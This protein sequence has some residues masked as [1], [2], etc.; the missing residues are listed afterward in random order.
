MT[1]KVPY[2]LVALDLDGTLLT[3]DHT[4]SAETMTALDRVRQLG[5]KIVI[6]TGKTRRSADV[7]WQQLGFQGAGVYSQGL[8]VYDETDKVI[9]RRKLP[10]KVV[11]ELEEW[12]RETQ[13]T[14]IAY[15][16]NRLLSHQPSEYSERLQN[17]HEPTVEMVES[18]AKH[19]INKIIICAPVP[20]LEANLPTLSQRWPRHVSLIRA[21]IADFVEM[22]PITSSKGDGLRRLLARLG[23]TWL[24]VLAMGNAENDIE[25]LL[26]AGCGVA[27]DNAPDI[28]KAAANF[29]APSNDDDGVAVALGHLFA[30]SPA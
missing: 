10:T 29:V 14:L 5:V 7:V 13:F 30:L 9:Y 23:L 3:N 17:Y 22:V 26:W 12:A 8:I 2:R 19:E 6:A 27:V 1:Q 15:S 28:V 11:A 25:M 16:G 20:H 18:L 21:G 24:D 4:I